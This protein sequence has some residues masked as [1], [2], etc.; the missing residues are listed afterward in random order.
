M[1]RWGSGGMGTG[2][3][4]GRSFILAPNSHIS[5]SLLARANY[6]GAIRVEHCFWVLLVLIRIIWYP[7][8]SLGYNGDHLPLTDRGK[9]GLSPVTDRDR[10]AL[11]NLVGGSHSYLEEL[12]H[13]MVY[14]PV[15]MSSPITTTLHASATTRHC[16]W[17]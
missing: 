8:R 13:S 4:V 2:W 15:N 16:L 12:V 6:I 1:G 5:S 17:T 11:Q 14:S 3:E 9:A 10:P 7:T